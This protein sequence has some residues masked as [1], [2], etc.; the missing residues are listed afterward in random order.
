MLAQAEHDPA[1]RAALVALEAVL[2]DAVELEL[3]AALD[4][5]PEP[6]ASVARASLNSGGWAFAASSRE[7]A[8]AAADRF[9]PEHLEILAAD[10][11]FYDRG[12]TNAGA[13]FLGSGA[14][15]VLGDYGA[16]PN[17]CL[18][19]GG[20]SR[21]AAGLSVLSFLRARTYLRLEDPRGIAADAA[22]FARLEG[23]EAHARSA[24]L[25]G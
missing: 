15:E 17:H 2:V 10:P 8:C 1:A 22:A 24:E 21:F 11:E 7:E 16:G 4:R 5:L 6:S 14:A 18:P 19:T 25:R 23:L 13:V 9:A 20:A 3:A 12:V